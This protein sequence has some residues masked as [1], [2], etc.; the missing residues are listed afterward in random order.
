MAKRFAH[1]TGGK[2]LVQEHFAHD[3]SVADLVKRHKLGASIN[4]LSAT[5]KPMFG[6]FTAVSFQSM[7]DAIVDANRAFASLP[8]SVRRRFAN[9][10]YQ[11][12][13]MIDAAKAGSESA[14]NELKKMDLL[15]VLPEPVIE[16]SIAEQVTEGVSKALQAK[17]DPEA[18]PRKA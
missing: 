6:D 5:R 11:L 14:V 15:H 3:S 12:I 10:P 13:R 4:D 17:P 7:Q 2:K 8:S 9:Q 1:P 18:N 16:K